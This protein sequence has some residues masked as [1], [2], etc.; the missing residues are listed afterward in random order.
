MNWVVPLDWPFLSD[1][2]TVMATHTSTDVDRVVTGLA[3]KLD[4]EPGYYVGVLVDSVS[5]MAKRF[6]ENLTRERHAK[7]TRS[8]MVDDE[9]EMIETLYGVG[10]RFK[11]A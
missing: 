6:T 3:K 4:E 9:F 8:G 7:R 5:E 1:G 10:Y 11:E 2:L